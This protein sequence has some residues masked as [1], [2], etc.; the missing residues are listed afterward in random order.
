MNVVTK[1]VTNANG[2]T[3]SEIVPSDTLSFADPDP[4]LPEALASVENPLLPS[5]K[6]RD[7]RNPAYAAQA[8]AR[9]AADI[10][11]EPVVALTPTT[12]LAPVASVI[13]D[14]PNMTVGVTKKTFVVKPSSNSAGGMN[15]VSSDSKIVEVAASGKS[16]VTLLALTEGQATITVNQE[17]SGIYLPSSKS[18]VVTVT[19]DSFAPVITNLPDL[20]KV[21]GGSTFT[22]Q[23]KSDST[24][25]LTFT[26]L[27]SDVVKICSVCKFRE[28]PDGYRS[29]GTCGQAASVARESVGKGMNAFG[30]KHHTSKKIK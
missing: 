14:V 6:D 18:F 30:T 9:N 8:A 21:L 22:I 26:S 19:N 10:T 27:D 28:I 24:G 25:N 7:L 23:P 29:C 5:T 20:N 2:V 13:S 11:T 12:T 15:F 16:N 17:A 1:N 3:T 4:S